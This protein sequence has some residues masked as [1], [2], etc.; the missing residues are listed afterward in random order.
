MNAT[1]AGLFPYVA[2]KS[3]AFPF[4]FFGCMMLVQF[5]VVL[6]S[7][8]ETKGATLETIQKRMKIA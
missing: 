7:Y 5:V 6:V 4:V 2:A 1:I 3:Q 8:P